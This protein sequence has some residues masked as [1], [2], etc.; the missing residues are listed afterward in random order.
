MIDKY[1]GTSLVVGGGR[2]TLLYSHRCRTKDGSRNYCTKQ[3][4][5]MVILII[6]MLINWWK[7]AVI[8]WCIIG[9]SWFIHI[10]IHA[11]WYKCVLFYYQRS[12][13]NK[14]MTYLT[15]YI[16]LHYTYIHIYQY[17]ISKINENAVT[18]GRKKL[19]IKYPNIL[20]QLFLK[21]FKIDCDI[22]FFT[23]NVSFLFNI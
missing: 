3:T 20:K 9:C 15:V 7:F 23:Y 10:H 13:I 8:S 1:T 11:G 6:D 12:C 5:Q 2:C 21:K 16:A 18:N 4:K 22:D 17:I 14:P 19:Y